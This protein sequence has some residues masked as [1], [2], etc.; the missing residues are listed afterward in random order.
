MQQRRGI[1][2]GVV[3]FDLVGPPV[4]KK[5]ATGPVSG[6]LRRDLVT[7][8]NMLERLHFEAEAIGDAQQHQDF[9][10]PVTMAMNLER[11]VE[12]VGERLQAQIA[13][14]GHGILVLAPRFLVVVPLFY[15]SLRFA[16]GAHQH[17]FYAQARV[18][19]AAIAAL[20]VF[21]QRELDAAR[22]I[23]Q[24]H[25]VSAGAVLHFD[26]GIL[27]ADAVSATV[28]QAGRGDTAG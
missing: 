24:Q 15:I 20:H 7:F 18:R 19:K 3:G 13:P 11:A 14:W 26:D 22:R 4:G 5:T 27:P 16:E 8:Q 25:L 1:G 17:G 6:D 23:G 9:V 10:G 12:D 2:N 21:A 28:Q